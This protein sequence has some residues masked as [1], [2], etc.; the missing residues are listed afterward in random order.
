MSAASSVSTGN[1][2]S[3]ATSALATTSGATAASV[4]AEPHTSVATSPL[5]RLPAELRNRIYEYVLDSKPRTASSVIRN[6]L[7]ELQF[8]AEYN[9][10]ETALLAVCRSVRHEAM[11]YFLPRTPYKILVVALGNV[12][13]FEIW[14]RRLQSIFWK[15]DSESDD[16]GS[17]YMSTPSLEVLNKGAKWLE[18]AQLCFHNGDEDAQTET[19]VARMVLMRCAIVKVDRQASRKPWDPLE[20]MSSMYGRLARGKNEWKKP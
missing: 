12:E 9:V 14:E 16:T 15:H 19:F 8:T 1:S 6:I 18:S 7:E 13:P 20:G 2:A 17:E 10:A 4:S 5:F 3:G 11:G